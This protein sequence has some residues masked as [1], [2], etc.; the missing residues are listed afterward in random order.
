MNNLNEYNKKRNFKKTKEPI[1][2]K[3]KV[4]NKRFV[5]QHHLARK[6][7]YDFRLEYNGVLI[8]FA[9]PKGPSYNQKDKRL[10][11]HVEDHPISYR[12]FEGIIPKGEY[13]A[14]T[15]MLWDRGTYKEIEPFKTTLKK[16]Y[17]KFELKG[18][19]LKGKWTLMLNNS[20]II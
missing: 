19:R 17:L 16:G 18:K 11:V 6:D 14:G 4:N 12:N 5:V 9:V 20:E 8:S 7:H 2:K 1:G 3:E 15:V 10:A 13:G